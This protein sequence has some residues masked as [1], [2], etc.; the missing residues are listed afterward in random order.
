[1]FKVTV[2]KLSWPK[3]RATFS[4]GQSLTDCKVD[5]MTFLIGLDHT[6]KI[7]PVRALVDQMNMPEPQEHTNLIVAL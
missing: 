5:L 6:F 7:P 4:F 1:M 3:Y 2:I